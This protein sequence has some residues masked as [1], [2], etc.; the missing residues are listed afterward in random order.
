MVPET[1]QEIGGDKE[2]IKG[3][4]KLPKKKTP[5]RF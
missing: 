2:A 3:M 5:P 1:G 4:A